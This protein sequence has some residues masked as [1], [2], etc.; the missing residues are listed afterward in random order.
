MKFNLV[1]IYCTGLISTR[2]NQSVII[3]IILLWPVLFSYVLF[4]D[5]FGFSWNEGRGGFLIVTILTIIEIVGSHPA[6]TGRKI[7]LLIT[8]AILTGSYFFTLSF[9]TSYLLLDMGRSVG[10]LI[11]ESWMLMWDYIILA[12]YF[13][14]TLVLIF[15]TK[16]WLRIGGAATLFLVGYVT[17]LLLDSLFPY[18]TLGILQYLVP[19]YLHFNVEIL[20]SIIHFLNLETGFTSQTFGNTL[21]L[22]SP[23]GPFV[24][25]VYWP[26]AGIHSIVIFSLVMFAFLLKTVIPWKKTLI[27]LFSGIILTCIV[28][29]IR[30]TLLSLYALNPNSD[31]G[32]WEQ[33]H[34]VIGEMVFIP[35]VLFYLAVVIYLE[36]RYYKTRRDLSLHGNSC[37]SKGR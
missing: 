16:E 28:N 21:V 15:G 25:K 20:N 7:S 10:A 8:F 13:G 30:I 36:N 4:P 3:I 32:S 2:Y 24:M 26:S 17:I 23:D 22:Y 31:L 27:Y 14:I 5:T 1:K 33:F 35:W 18:D 29:C 12:I 34:S 11:S 6:I 19:T 9:G 37:S